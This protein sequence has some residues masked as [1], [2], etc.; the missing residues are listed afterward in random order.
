[1]TEVDRSAPMGATERWLARLAY[2]LALAAVLV[3]LVRGVTTSLGVLVVGAVGLAAT[4]VGG[5]WFLS[6]RGVVR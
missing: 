1:M 3:L 4:L 5:W 6:N 2:L